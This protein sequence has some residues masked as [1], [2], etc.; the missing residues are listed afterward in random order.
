MQGE[1]NSRFG[2]FMGGV[3]LV[4]L[5]LG[6]AI[7]LNVILHA[8]APSGGYDLLWF[9]VYPGWSWYATVTAIIGVLAALI[10]SAM[11][12]FG[13]TDPSGPLSLPDAEGPA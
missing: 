10:G 1:G 13:F 3:I 8:T 9:K 6:C 4:V 2:F 12:W 7:I 5:G 11:V